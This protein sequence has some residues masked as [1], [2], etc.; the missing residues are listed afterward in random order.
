MTNE[1]H[2]TTEKIT[3]WNAIWLSKYRRFHKLTTHDP[4]PVN[5]DAIIRFLRSLVANGKP[6]WQRLQAVQVLH[7]AAL[8]AGLPL[9]AFPA[10]KTK[11]ASLRDREMQS[12]DAGISDPLEPPIIQQL[13][14]EIRLRHLALKTE[15]AYA[16]WIM[17]FMRRFSIAN[18]SSWSE[19]SGKHVREFLT[20]L[21]VE[22]N[23]AA[24]TQNQALSALLFVFQRLLDRKLE[25][26]DAVRAKKPERLPSVLSEDEI[27]EIFRFLL[28][29]DL[30]MGRLLYGSGMRGKE[31][32]RL[33]IKDIDFDR[34]QIIIR[35]A[36]GQKD[37]ATL[38]PKSLR[39]EM[40]DIIDQRRRLYELDLA[41]GTGAVYLPFALA[42]K[43]PTRRKNGLAVSVR[44][45]AFKP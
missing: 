2:Q 14:K 38:F 45:R 31:L 41:A 43:Y 24:S 6:A 15:Q 29:R 42:R 3:D 19:I 36:K 44:R 28:G 1:N 33:R 4:L 8:S 23:V 30:F 18:D 27:N 37:R 13:R 9:D 7:D 26:I 20:E 34:G 10:I 40:Q 5:S 11:L 39:D 35:D 16:Q 12:G 25:P 22:G 17:R 32:V 21:A